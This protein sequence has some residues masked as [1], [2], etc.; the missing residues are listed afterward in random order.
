MK[1]EDSVLRQDLVT[2]DSDRITVLE[3]ETDRG[4]EEEI[5]FEEPV[6]RTG[7]SGNHRGDADST[8]TASQ[9]SSSKAMRFLSYFRGDAR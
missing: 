6:R 5:I 8:E 3:N 7:G 2:D 9:Q 4:F 1:L